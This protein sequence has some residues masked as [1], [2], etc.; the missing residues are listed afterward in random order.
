VAFLGAL[1]GVVF[2]ALGY[3][4]RQSP[5]SFE[6]DVYT[7]LG[8]F[9]TPLSLFLL[10]FT[11]SNSVDSSGNWGDSL[12]SGVQIIAF[13]LVGVAFLCLAIYMARCW[14]VQK[15][16]HFAHTRAFLE[17][18][19]P[20]LIVVPSI[21][22]SL[23]SDNFAYTAALILCSLVVTV[24]SY[25]ISVETFRLAGWG[26]LLVAV[27][28]LLSTLFHSLAAAW[29][30]ALVA[31]GI[32]LV[33]ASVLIT[34][35][36]IKR[37]TNWFIAVPTESLFGLGEPLPV[38]QHSAPAPG[39]SNYATTSGT[40]STVQVIVWLFVAWLAIKFLSYFGFWFGW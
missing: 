11:I 7:Q 26:G 30:I 4:H 24:L 31:G 34:H 35:F 28:P 25:S 20:F 22:A 2:L 19:A 32:I 9:V 40:S 6:R 33:S 29:P 14:K 1:L 13:T 27:F 18:T 8:I 12:I 15:A 37:V 10:P 39:H 36:E 17:S 5:L 3:P 21:V 16:P 23:S 38:V